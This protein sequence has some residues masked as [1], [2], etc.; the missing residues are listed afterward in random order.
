MGLASGRCRSGSGSSLEVDVEAQQCPEDQF[1]LLR[2][3][4]VVLW[5]ACWRLFRD[6]T[7]AA[8]SRH[9]RDQACRIFILLYLRDEGGTGGWH[10]MA[11]SGFQLSQA[12]I[13]QVK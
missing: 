4:K 7:A 9:E 13:E 3:V 10:E 8:A 11:C 1:C 5:G 6:N 12:S 2:R